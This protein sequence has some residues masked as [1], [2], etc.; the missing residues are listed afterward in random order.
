MPAATGHAVMTT[1]AIL[2]NHRPVNESQKSSQIVDAQLYI[3]SPN[4]TDAI[5]GFRYYAGPGCRPTS[6]SGSPAVYLIVVKVS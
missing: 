6:D 3:G 1:L 5:C 2:G 4:F